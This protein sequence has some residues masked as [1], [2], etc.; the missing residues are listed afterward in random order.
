MLSILPHRKRL[1][2]DTTN[3]RQRVS[4]PE[5]DSADPLPPLSLFLASGLPARPLFGSPW[6]R[7]AS[8]LPGR[9]FDVGLPPLFWFPFFSFWLAS[10]TDR[11]LICQEWYYGNLH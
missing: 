7:T 9:N 11:V 6:L 3:Q 10:G 5:V 8:G 1:P 2:G 4:N